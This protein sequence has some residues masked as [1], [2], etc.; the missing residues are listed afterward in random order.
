MFKNVGGADIPSTVEFSE[1][2]FRKYREAWK[3]YRSLGHY[4]GNGNWV[5]PLSFVEALQ[6]PA[7]MLA[8]FQGLD[9][10]LEQMKRHHAKKQGL[11]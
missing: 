7:E 4:D 1:E 9:Q 6:L 10:F 2:G 3:R 5:P 8:V 11:K